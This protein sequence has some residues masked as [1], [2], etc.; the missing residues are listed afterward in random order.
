MPLYDQKHP[1]SQA[2]SLNLSN[3]SVLRIHTKPPTPVVAPVPVRPPSPI[4][5]ASVEERR[6]VATV[7]VAMR[8]LVEQQNEAL[9]KAIDT[10]SITVFNIMG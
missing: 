3:P 2:S 5:G 1:S 10:L 4:G 6:Q 8:K 9:M 7:I